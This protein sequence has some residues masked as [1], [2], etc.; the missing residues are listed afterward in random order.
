M[1]FVVKIVRSAQ[2]SLQR[3]T[4]S[5]YDRIKNVIY[6]LSKEPRPHGCKKLIGRDAWRVRTGNYRIIYEI[7]DREL[8]VLIIHIGH[9]KDIYKQP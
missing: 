9:R 8:V 5:D 6:S 1:M 2:K 3:V 4:G 7:R